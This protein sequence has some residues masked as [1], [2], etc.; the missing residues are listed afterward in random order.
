MEAVEA[1]DREGGSTVSHELLATIASAASVLVTIGTVVWRLSARLHSLAAHLTRQTDQI[2]R[3]DGELQEIKTG[4]ASATRG[5]QDLWIEL[6]SA[7]ERIAV[8]FERVKE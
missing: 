8:L 3:L 7:R 5:R 4:M 1:V 6:N 2:A